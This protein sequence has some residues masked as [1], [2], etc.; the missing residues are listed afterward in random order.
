MSSDD[1][2]L[3]RIVLTFTMAFVAAEMAG[4]EGS[5]IAAL[6]A[7]ALST[8]RALP[9]P[10]LAA[11][12]VAMWSIMATVGI[13]VQGLATVPLVL[14]SVLLAVLY[15]GFVLSAR[16]G[17]EALGLVILASFA[18]LPD[19]LVKAPELAPDFARWCA[20][21]V[22]IACLATLIA[23]LLIPRS[24]LPQSS[25]DQV[26]VPPVPPIIAACALLFAVLMVVSFSP[27]GANAVLISVILV[28]KADAAVPRQI[29]RN[30][31]LAALLGGAA[32]SAVWQVI[33]FVPGLLVLATAILLA[34]WLLGRGITGNG[35]SRDLAKKSLNVL[36]ILLGKGM[37]FYL[38]DTDA[39]L[40]PRLAGVAIG[41]AYA[42]VI[43]VMFTGK[44]Q[45]LI[46]A[47]GPVARSEVM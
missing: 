40:G 46:G 36:A 13:V 41:V 4:L 28:L 42:I 11:L 31:V 7:V 10:L 37:S 23:A 45:A 32:A 3:L 14:C 9:L 47:D 20:A 43:V 27:P 29:I 26:P 19:M 39:L 33:W 17:L 6:F 22:A 30:R 12:P 15:A 1:R 18:V 2:A 5:F 24:T 8:G 34:G 38:D 25:E 44:P 21:N 16:R 35:Q